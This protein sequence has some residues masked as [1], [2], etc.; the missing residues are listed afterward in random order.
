MTT[1]SDFLLARIADDVATYRAEMAGI[2]W[3]TVGGRNLWT[4]LLAGAEADRRI[5]AMH[6]AWPVLVETEP[7]ME[8]MPNDFDPHIMTFRMTKR[9][10]WLTQREYVRRF[11]SEPPH[12]PMLM[13]MAQK[14]ADHP[15]FRDEWRLA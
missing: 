8:S 15:D 4:H 5:I 2:E 14:Y 13:A 6:D 1:L 9:I 7:V 10:E 11:G 12:A 3:V